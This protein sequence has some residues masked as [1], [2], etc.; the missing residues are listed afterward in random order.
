MM[1]LWTKL[2]VQCQKL[3]V[4]WQ[5]ILDHPRKIELLTVNLFVWRSEFLSQ[6]RY[7]ID[8]HEH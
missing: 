7:T 1:T 3:C 4:Q 6:Q 2:C 8:F 5:N